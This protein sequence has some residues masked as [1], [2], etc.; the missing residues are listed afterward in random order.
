MNKHL[1]EIFPEPWAWDWGKDSFGL[2]MD[3]HYKS[4]HQRFRWIKPGEFL[5]GSPESE[6]GRSSDEHQHKVIITQ[7]FWMADTACTQALWQA[8]MGEYP[9]RF[10]GDNLPVDSV[11]WHD[12]QSFIAR[13]NKTIPG[14]ELTLPTEAQWEYACRAGTIT[15]YHFGNDI[16]TDQVNFDGCYPLYNVKNG[17]YR[18]KTMPVKSFACNNWGLYEMHGNVWEWC[19]DWYKPY[20]KETVVDPIGPNEGEYRVLRGSSWFSYGW[21]IRSAY[22]YRSVPADHFDTYGF[23]LVSPAGISI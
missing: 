14:L 15:P 2:W 23:R 20:T 11:S 9:S 19:A 22:R 5:M 4:A 12:C 13:I 21:N 18:R 3:L 17:N 8:V 1:P 7:D 10:K 6:P 16:T